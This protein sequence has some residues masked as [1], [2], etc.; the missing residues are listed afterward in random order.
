[1]D[2]WCAFRQSHTRAVAAGILLPFYNNPAKSK[3]EA[4]FVRAHAIFRD[5]ET[6]EEVA[7]DAA[8]WMEQEYHYI[9]LR[10]GTQGDVLLVV[11]KV[12]ESEMVVMQ[13]NRSDYRVWEKTGF[14]CAAIYQLGKREYAVEIHLIWGGDD[15]F[16]E[17]YTLP[18]DLRNPEELFASLPKIQIRS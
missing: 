17:V 6:R 7:I 13:D 10:R 12:N 3:V 2:A 1:M 4:E 8:F 14:N 9:N 15:Q 18:L 5:S 11:Y 16:S